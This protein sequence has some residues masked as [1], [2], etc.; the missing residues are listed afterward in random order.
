VSTGGFGWGFG[1]IQV[2]AHRSGPEN[3]GQTD[4]KKPDN[5]IPKRSGRLY[6]RRDHVFQERSGMPDCLTLP[7]CSYGSKTEY[8]WF[9]VS[10][11]SVNCRSILW[12][13]LVNVV[14]VHYNRNGWMHIHMWNAGRV[15]RIC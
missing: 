13:P 8:W 2:G 3:Y 12:V 10:Q 15:R 7:H 9:A 14:Y 4:E 1:K 5:L 11:L 6:D